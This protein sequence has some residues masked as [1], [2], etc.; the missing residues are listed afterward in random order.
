MLEAFQ[1]F[2]PRDLTRPSPIEDSSPAR[3]SC[4]KYC[5]PAGSHLRTMA[6]SPLRSVFHLPPAWEPGGHP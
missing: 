4:S 3:T 2:I 6:P 1:P 5:W